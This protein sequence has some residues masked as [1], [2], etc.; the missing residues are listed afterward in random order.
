MAS[1]IAEN[2]KDVNDKIKA[3]GRVFM[4]RLVKE[5]KSRGFAKVHGTVVASPR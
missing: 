1:A 3:D 4:A 2:F 5:S